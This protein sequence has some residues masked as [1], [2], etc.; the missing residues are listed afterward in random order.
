MTRSSSRTAIS[1][2]AAWRQSNPDSF[3]YNFRDAFGQKQ[4]E[5]VKPLGGWDSQ[6][7]RLRGHAS[8]HYL[9]AIAQ[10]YAGTT[11]DEALRAN[12][13]QKMNYLIDT[14]YDLSQKSGRPAQEGGQFNADPTAVPPG[15]G[16]TGYDS[17][18]RADGIR[19]DYWNWGKGFISA[20]PPD[21]FIMLEQGATYGGQN[22]QIWAPYYTLHKILAGLLDCY[23]V[24]GNQKALEIAKNMG[25]WVYAR[26]KVLPTQTRIS[27]WNRYIAGEYGGMN[28]VMARLYR[29]TGTSNSSNAPSCSTTS[30]SS[31][32]TP[33]TSTAWPRTSIRFAASTP[34]STSRRSPARWKPSATRRNSPTTGSPTISGIS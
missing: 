15:P 20:Y 11:Y 16:R 27:M 34:T 10:A 23:E 9:S 19:T 1:S 6:T 13:L 18:L 31:S 21:Q 22:T 29:L 4:P 26:L 7:T 32:A 30:T 3:L 24:G 12:F 33:I 28:E 8:G 25:A 2:S 5:G 17:N 14:L